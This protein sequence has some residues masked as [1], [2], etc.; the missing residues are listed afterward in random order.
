MSD[1]WPRLGLGTWRM[2]ERSAR[3]ASEVEALRY[4]LD[5][6]V[7]LID[8]AEMYGDGEAESI[9]GDVIAGRRDQVTIVSKCYPHNAAA[10]TMPAACDRSLAR[11]RVERIDCYLLH[12]R[13]RVPLA[14]TV[15]TFER[16]VRKGKIATWGVSNFDVDDM[17]E[18][19]AVPGGTN[20][21][22]NQVQYSLGH[23]EPEWKLA[24]LCRSH[25]VSLMAYSP[26]GQGDLVRHK[27]LRAIAEARGVTPAQLALAFVMARPGVV[28]IPK[29]VDRSHVRE[30]I[31]AQNIELDEATLAKLDAAF[32]PPRRAVRV[33]VN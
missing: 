21:T 25:G 16:L 14:E 1:S 11:L 30:D 12:W 22:T 26:L 33:A 13:G 20:C 15:D 17:N 3:R 18:L 28:A 8:T 24:E 27:V 31:E 32:P 4:G 9:V 6:G 29:A 23:R 7:R 10:R 2:G 5:L 19:F